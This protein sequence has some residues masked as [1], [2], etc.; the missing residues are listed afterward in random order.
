MLLLV[1]IRLSFICVVCLD[2]FASSVRRGL[3][4]FMNSVE[5]ALKTDQNSIPIHGASPSPG[6]APSIADQWDTLSVASSDSDRYIMVQLAGEQEAC[7]AFKLD[8]NI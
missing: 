7:N 8:L 6:A 1:C 5:A 3:T 2:P 4:T